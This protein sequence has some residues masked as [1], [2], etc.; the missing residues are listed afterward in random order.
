MPWNV[1]RISSCER[2]REKERE[3]E[4]VGERGLYVGKM[5]VGVFSGYCFDFCK[6]LRETGLGAMGIG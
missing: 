2:D 3:R 6:D 4:L 1:L 5:C